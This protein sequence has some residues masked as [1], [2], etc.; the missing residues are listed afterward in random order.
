MAEVFR[1]TYTVTDPRTG[2]RAKRKSKT[3]HIRYYLP[4]GERKRVKGYTD[5]KAT[6]A[7]AAELER[8]GIR[9]D[10]HQ[11]WPRPGRMGRADH[12]A[13]PSPREVSN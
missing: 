11:S 9:V 4:S 6:E 2:Q 3:W 5:K 12:E 1:P 7:K 10:L 13:A 8:R